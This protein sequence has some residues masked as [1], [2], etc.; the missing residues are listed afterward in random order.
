MSIWS[1]AMKGYEA[2]LTMGL[3]DHQSRRRL[4]SQPSMVELYREIIPTHVEE[5]YTSITPCD[6]QD[7]NPFAR[8]PSKIHNPT[9]TITSFPFPSR[10]ILMIRI[11]QS[12]HID[13]SSFEGSSFLLTF[14]DGC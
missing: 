10:R 11:S 7:T 14:D 3:Y 12:L 13:R 6:S 4:I 8:M 9:S 5:P 1:M 2:S